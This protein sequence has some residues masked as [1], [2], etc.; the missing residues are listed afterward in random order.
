MHVRAIVAGLGFLTAFGMS[1]AASAEEAEAE[2]RVGED[3]PESTGEAAVSGSEVSYETE[4]T[5][6]RISGVKMNTTLPADVIEKEALDRSAPLTVGEAAAKLPGVSLNAPAGLLY[7][8]PSI[9]GLGGRRVVML[10]NNRRIDSGKPIGVSGYFLGPFNTD[11]IEVV[12]GPGAVRYGSDAIGGVINA[13]SP[14]PL[15]RPGFTGG[16]RLLIG[17]N[18]D[19]LASAVFSGYGGDRFGVRVHGMLRSAG[20]YRTGSGEVVENSFFED[21]AVGGSLAFKPAAGHEISISSDAYFGG[22]SGRAVNALDEE[23]RRRISFPSDD[24][25]LLDVV[26]RRRIEGGNVRYLE[27]GVYFDRTARD[28][29]RDLFSEDY[30]RVTSRMDQESRFYTA[31]ARPVMVLSPFAQ[32][33]LTLGADGRLR[34]LSMDQT[35]RTYLPGGVSPPPNRSRPYDGARRIDVGLFAEDEQQLGERVTVSAGLRGDLISQWYPESGGAVREA[36]EGAVSGNLGLLYRPRRWLALTL[37]GGRAF[38]APTLDEKFVELAFCKGVVC[39]R[40]DVAPERS[41]QVDAGVKGFFGVFGFEVYF[42]NTFIDDFITLAD[43]S[44]AHCDYVYV[45]VPR[46]WLI[47]GEARLAVDLER[48]VGGVGMR[49]WTQ[50]AYTRGEDRDTGAPLPQIA[51]L[52]ETTGLRLYGGSW[53]IVRAPYIEA[54]LVYNAP[55]HRISPAGNVASQAETETGQYATADLSAGLGLVDMP[56]KLNLDLALRVRNIADTAYRNH[57]SVVPAMGRNILLSVAIHY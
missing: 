6:P 4:V 28:L 21:K 54:V 25:L 3:A 43:S 14:D 42:F 10:R 37:N 33:E 50:V 38:R 16:Y 11:R 27:L 47:G 46:A 5:A 57:L 12:R 1:S 55:Q 40:P 26:Y 29:R 19:E 39:G 7:T 18:N 13:R 52:V 36:Q 17:T 44:D 51:P 9:R 15:G 31:G 41:W 48:L 22:E 35:I 49:V 24:N 32:N 23:K 45:N 34:T 30:H 56:D 2:D 20:N 8:N 53:R